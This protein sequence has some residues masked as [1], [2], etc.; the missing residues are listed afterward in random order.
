[1]KA[2]P[3]I[4]TCV[5]LASGGQILL[6]MEM[7][8]IGPLAMNVITFLSTVPKL[9]ADPLIW[10]GFFCYGVA[11]MVWLVVL[12]REELSFAYPFASLSYI[13][14]VFFSWWLFREQVT[15]ARLVGILIVFAGV[16]LVSRT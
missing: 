3:L 10:L 16:Y 7:L 6:R 9:V 2:I 13:I 12:S 5:L 4:L 15:I 1:M 8:K 14:I 11:G